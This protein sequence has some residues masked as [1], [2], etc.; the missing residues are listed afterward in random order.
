MLNNPSRGE[1]GDWAHKHSFP[2]RNKKT[3]FFSLLTNIFPKEDFLYVQK[4]III[5]LV[6][7]KAMGGEREQVFEKKN[8]HIG[9]I[10][11]AHP[12]IYVLMPWL[13]LSSFV[14]IST[15]AAQEVQRRD[16]RT[17]NNAENE[18]QVVDNPQ[19]PLFGLLK[20]DLQEEIT[21][22][23]E[24]DKDYLFW[25]IHA[26]QVD[27]EGRIYVDDARNYRIQVFDRSGRYVQTI[28]RQGQGPGEFQQPTKLRLLNKSR[29]LYVRDIPARR[30]LIFSFNGDYLGSVPTGYVIRDYYPLEG[31][32]FIA[33]FTRFSE[34]DL[35]ATQ[36]LAKLNSEGNILKEMGTF[37]SNPFVERTAYGISG[38]TTGYELNLHLA[39][40]RNDRFVYGFSKEY[41]LL[42]VD[43][44]LKPL[45]VV[46]KQ[47][48]P[49]TFTAHEIKA[50]KKTRLPKPKPYF[51]GLLSD[52]KGRI[53][54]QKNFTH[55][56]NS[57]QDDVQKEVDVFGNDGA[58]LYKSSLPP[59]TSVI[60]DGYLYSYSIDWEV[61]LETVHRYRVRNWTQIKEN[62]NTSRD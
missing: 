56:K 50:F 58:F 40:L 16:T 13:I 12:K 53:Y 11:A 33:V 37:L 41:K 20:L 62:G 36:S 27:D 22:G 42:V 2:R 15:L 49:P 17:K 46:K 48:N 30:I 47:E 32:E 24:D 54:V 28:G 21:I 61:G 44:D 31:S 8:G 3:S 26:L 14:S 5:N 43:M 29:K 51:F 23:R 4:L 19:E 55:N 7:Y 1:E 34:A 35:L 59:N 38:G 57:V 10:V 9:K 39:P 6:R 52:S 45:F 18:L 60:K 25:L